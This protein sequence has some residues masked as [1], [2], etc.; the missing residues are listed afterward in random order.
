MRFKLGLKGSMSV[1]V[2]GCKQQKASL[3]S[4]NKKEESVGRRPG[5]HGIVSRLK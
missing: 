2:V 5:T 4:S 3:A 1:R